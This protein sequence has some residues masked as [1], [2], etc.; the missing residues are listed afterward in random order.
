MISSVPWYGVKGML[1]ISR[2]AREAGVGVETVRFYQRKGLLRLPELPPGGIRRYDTGD[3]ARLRF[4]KS[5]QRL[6][7]SLAEIGQLLQLEDGLHCDEAREIAQ[8]KLLGVRARKADLE[9]MEAVLSTLVADC[10]SVAGG[11]VGCPL[12]EALREDD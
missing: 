4:I 5:A 9:R 2:L 1:T 10:S 3:V 8:R 12:I 7:F 6:G 11:S